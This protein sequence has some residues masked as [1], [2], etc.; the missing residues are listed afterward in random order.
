[1][2][3]K[4]DSNSESDTEISN[5]DIIKADTISDSPSAE[6]ICLDLNLANSKNNNKY[7]GTHNRQTDR[8]ETDRYGIDRHETYRSE[9]THHY[10][11]IDIYELSRNVNKI[12]CIINSI[13][14]LDRKKG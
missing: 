8:R 6:S 7:R 13:K 14:M 2:H 1:M 11:N 12:V 3:Q 10:Q 4:K 9:Q 5:V